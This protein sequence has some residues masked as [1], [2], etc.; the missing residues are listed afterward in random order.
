MRVATYNIEWFSELFDK[1]DTL[2]LDAEWSHRYNVTRKEQGEAIAEVLRKLDA[3]LILVVEAPNTGH[4]QDSLRAL[5][6]FT[7]HFNLRQNA[8][9][10]GYANATH[11]ELVVLYDPTVVEVTHDPQG[12]YSDGTHPATAPRFDSKF[13]YDVDVDGKP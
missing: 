8:S 6:R 10:M 9:V 7:K 12:Q 2:L 1:Q 4:N 13:R 11:Q 3:D 5:N